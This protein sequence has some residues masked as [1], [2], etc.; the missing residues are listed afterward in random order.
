VVHTNA[1]SQVDLHRLQLDDARALLH[2]NPVA[3]LPSPEESATGYLQGVINGLCELSLQDP[4]TGLAN[5]K[6]LQHIQ[7]RTLDSVIRS[8][9]PALLLMLEIDNLHHLSETH[10]ASV[11]RQL[12][13]V[14]SKS[15]AACLRSMDCLARFDAHTLSVVMPSCQPPYG[16]M[17]AERIRDTVASLT[18]QLSDTETVQVSTSIG[19]AF[20][21][22]WIHTTPDQW[23]QNALQQLQIASSQGGNRVEI[24]PIE[25]IYVSAEEKNLLFSHLGLIDS[26]LTD[27]ATNDSKG[28]R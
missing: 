11:Q 28:V 4:L 9:E 1:P 13:P 17:I 6:H 26:A 25:E 27:A 2:H 3:E 23:S 12:L 10:G 19:G 20:A 15:V 8:G 18:L 16:A 24:D 21:S 22:E 14:I 7:I 5:R